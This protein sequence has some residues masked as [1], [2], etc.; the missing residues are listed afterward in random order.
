MVHSCYDERFTR[1]RGR[2]YPCPENLLSNL[3]RLVAALANEQTPLAC[4]R[5]FHEGNPIPRTRWSPDF[6]LLNPDEIISPNYNLDEGF[7]ADIA[8]CGPLLARLQKHVPKLA[9]GNVEIKGRGSLA[10]LVASDVSKMRLP[11]MREGQNVMDY[12]RDLMIQGN[13]RWCYMRAHLSTIDQYHG[14]L[15]LL[16]EFPTV[17][18][19]RCPFIRKEYTIYLC[20]LHCIVQ[21]W[22]LG[23]SY[24]QSN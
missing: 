6:I 4:R 8:V 2:F 19:V 3:R 15:S 16:G 9:K 1:C 5:T 23:A 17:L 24:S 11:D 20:T 22:P 10:Q 18:N 14:A 13:T 21:A 7:R 12:Y